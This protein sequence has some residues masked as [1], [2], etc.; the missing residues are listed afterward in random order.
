MVNTDNIID[1]AMPMMRIEI[2]L[3]EMHDYLLDGHM[4]IAQDLSVNLITEAKLLCNT[5]ILM[6]ERQD[7]LRK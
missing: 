7:A 5:L 6:K 4:D 2:L 1:Y 3:R